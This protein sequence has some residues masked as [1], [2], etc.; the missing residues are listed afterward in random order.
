[1]RGGT[2]VGMYL[3]SFLFPI[4]ETIPC[5]TLTIRFISYT[6]HPHVE[7]FNQYFLVN[8][9]VYYVCMTGTVTFSLEFKRGIA[10]LVIVRDSLTS[11]LLKTVSFVTHTSIQ[12]GVLS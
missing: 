3:F 5:G 11:D 9:N 12:Q 7:G 2:D 6:D 8:L 1:M 10:Y 4:S